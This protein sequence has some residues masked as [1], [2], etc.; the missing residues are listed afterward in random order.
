MQVNHRSF[1]LIGLSLILLVGI[2]LAGCTPQKENSKEQGL[3]IQPE[4]RMTKI[5]ESK[6]L[7]VGTSADYP[8][9]EF[10]TMTD[11]GESIVGLDISI[12]K[13][14]AEELGVEIEIRDM[15]FDAV[16][17][18]VGTGMIDIG[19]ASIT[20]TEER[21]WAMDFS[22][23]YYQ[24][25]YTVLVQSERQEEY[26]TWDDLNGKIIGVQIGTVQEEIANSKC[27]GSEIRALAKVTDLV[28]DLKSA[29]IDAIILEDPVAQSYSKQNPDLAVVEQIK[30]ES[31]G[32][33]VAVIT[34]NNQDDL[35]KEIN[36]VLY[37]LKESGELDRFIVEA[38]ELAGSAIEK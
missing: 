18:E 9:Y 1:R 37:R 15:G 17:T 4:N 36:R 31:E 12:A 8:P 20:P 28:E 25:R 30:I 5:K 6:R 33:G 34:A 26:Q 11:G 14:I 27:K 38:N 24:A 23:I 19:I 3:P 32:N 2:M 16:L 22:D 21:D 10:Y 29:K 7:I 35:M 13:A